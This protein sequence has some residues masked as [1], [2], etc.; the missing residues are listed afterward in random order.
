MT[1]QPL[2]SVVTYKWTPQVGY[3]S[4]Y[5]PEQVNTLYRMVQRH[6]PHP[7]RF[8]CVTDD[9]TGIDPNVE[10]VQLWNDF[11]HLESPH[12][13]KNPSCYRRLK[14]F[15]PDIAKTFGKRFVSLDLDC[16]ISGDLTP[17]WH[18]AEDFVIWG[19]TNPRTAYNC[20]MYLLTAG[21]RPTVWQTFDPDRSP[22]EAKRA[23]CWGSD[24]GWISYCLGPKEAKWTRADGVYSFRND[25]KPHGRLLPKDAR[26]VL[27]HG[28]VDPWSHCAQQ[29]PW[30]GAHYQ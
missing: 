6:Y 27:F 17:L 4:T 7:H 8:I 16:V 2:E 12:G 15:S 14:A 11:G 28:A 30:V 13:R 3:R 10:I 26:I 9:P 18:R 1:P 23:G 21:A 5:G 20:S 24:Q 25:L 19:D 29:L 22:A